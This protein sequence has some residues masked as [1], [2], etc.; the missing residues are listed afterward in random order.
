[1]SEHVLKVLLSELTT[2]RVICGSCSAV[3]EMPTDKLSQLSL[4][5]TFCPVCHMAFPR[6]NEA[7]GKPDHLKR[8]ADAIA[9]LKT[10]GQELE[11]VV[12][13]PDPTGKKA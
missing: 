5:D 10:I 3:A 4:R 11:F 12:R 2:V 13:N 8:L 7:E 1:M 9:G 6:G